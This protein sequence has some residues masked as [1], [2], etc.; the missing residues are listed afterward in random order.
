MRSCSAT[1]SLFQFKMNDLN[2]LN[3]LANMVYMG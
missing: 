3:N 1:G 2:D